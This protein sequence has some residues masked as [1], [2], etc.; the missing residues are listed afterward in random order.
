VAAAAAPAA[1]VE[2]APPPPRSVVKIKGLTGT[3]NKDD[4]HQTMDARQEAFDACIKESRRKLRMVSGAIKFA[5]KVAADG[6]VAEVHAVESN[7]GHRALEACLTSAVAETHF[8]EPAGRATAEFEWGLNVDPATSRVPE[9]IEAEV[10]DRVLR[11]HTDKL[12]EHCEV[13]RPKERFA[14][15]AYLTRSG[16]VTS[17]GATARP[18]AAEAKV[19]CVLAELASLRMPRLKHEAKVRFELR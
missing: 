11:K 3:L 19:D 6:S 12:L 9:E 16:R 5:F 7:I 15:T 13:R 17:A 2:E 8:P 1:P 4:V 18:P 10:L 14:V